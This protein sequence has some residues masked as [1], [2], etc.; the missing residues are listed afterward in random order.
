MSDNKCEALTI[1]ELMG[2]LQILKERHEG[3]TRIQNTAQSGLI[4]AQRKWRGNMS[5]IVLSFDGWE[6]EQ[7][8]D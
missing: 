2:K 8:E 3:S 4:D 5:Y 1:D 7:D 6:E